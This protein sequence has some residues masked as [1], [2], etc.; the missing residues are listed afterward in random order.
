MRSSNHVGKNQPQ[1]SA[2]FTAVV[3]N[4]TFGWKSLLSWPFNRPCQEFPPASHKTTTPPNSPT[5]GWSR[6]W[7]MAGLV[8]DRIQN[9]WFSRELCKLLYIFIYA[10]PLLITRWL[11]NRNAY[12][13]REAI[14]IITSEPTLA[15]HHK[16]GSGWAKQEPGLSHID[17]LTDAWAANVKHISRQVLLRRAQTWQALIPVWQNTTGL[18]H[19]VEILP[20]TNHE[21]LCRAELVC[22]KSPHYFWHLVIFE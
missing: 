2:W 19:N 4:S 14:P 1:K 5:K 18:T 9:L 8:L 12:R 6:N 22:Q 10:W 17:E 11:V 20:E 7:L 16:G 21:T 3:C 15:K 13:E